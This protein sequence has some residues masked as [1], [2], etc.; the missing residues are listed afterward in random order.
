VSLCF[1]GD[2]LRAA[3]SLLMLCIRSIDAQ[4]RDV[5]TVDAFEISVFMKKKFAFRH[6]LVGTARITTA[7]FLSCLESKDLTFPLHKDGR[8]GPRG[9][10][11]AS[12]QFEVS[13]KS[14]GSLEVVR[15]GYYKDV[16]LNL[17]NH[18]VVHSLR[19]LPKGAE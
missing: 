3:L 15:P 10:I 7:D 19:E 9:D 6:H 11:L 13:N 16:T 17:I 8:E 5:K 4:S 1:V 2:A 18:V 14:V 12:V